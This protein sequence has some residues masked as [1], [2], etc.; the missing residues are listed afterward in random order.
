MIHKIKVNEITLTSKPTKEEAGKISNNINKEYN[1]SIKDLSVIVSQPYAYTWTPFYFEGKRKKENWISQSIF[2]LDFDNGTEINDIKTKL[3][4]LSLRPNI[5]YNTLSDTPQKR[6]FRVVFFLDGIIKCPKTAD[7]IQSKLVEMFPESD[8]NCKTRERMVYPGYSILHIDEL[9]NSGDDFVK[10]I[11]SYV[12]SRDKDGDTFKT[13]NVKDLEIIE[14]KEVFTIEVGFDDDNKIDDVLEYKLVFDK[15]NMKK[16]KLEEIKVPDMIDNFDWVKAFKEIRILKD[17]DDGIRLKHMQIFGLATNLQYIKGG[18]LYMKNKM[19]EVNNNP[20]RVDIDGKKAE[21]YIYQ[22]FA[23]LPYVKSRKY[24]PQS[25]EK[26]SVYDEDKEYFN[27]LE[28]TRWK[29]GRVDILKTE[30]KITLLEAE[31]KLIDEYNRVIN[32]I[33]Y[34]DNELFNLVDYEKQIIIFKV[35][36]GL[37]KTKLLETTKNTLIATKTNQLKRELS[38]RMEEEWYMTPDYPIFSSELIND[39]IRSYT[40][41]NL[42]EDTSRMIQRISEG[43]P[44]KL[45]NKKIFT[46]TQD[47]IDMAE[48]Y[49]KDNRVCRETTENVITTHTRAILDSNF[50]H[51]ILVFD[52][53]PLSDIVQIGRY[54]F[55]FTIFDNTEFTEDVKP[56]EDWLRFQVG[57]NQ[58]VDVPTFTI[59]NYNKFAEFCALN[60]ESNL[61]KLIDS[62]FC[63]KDEQ[64]KGQIMYAIKKQLP[65]KHIIIMSA[66]SPVEIYKYLFGDRVKVI[67]I[68][69]IEKVGKVVQYTEKSWSRTSFNN[70]YKSIGGYKSLLKLKQMVGDMAV[71]TFQKTKKEFPNELPYHFGN[72]SGYDT[73]RGKDL[74]IIGTDN[75]PIYVYFFYAK[76]IGMSPKGSDNKLSNRIVEWGDKRFKGMVFENPILMDIQLSLIVSEGIQASGRNRNLR[77]NCTS[78]VFSNIPLP[79][80]DEFREEY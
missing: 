7:W 1:V 18:L 50:K 59:K 56:I 37:G 74:C 24:L 47:D 43:K 45:E 11:N 63:Y 3:D 57:S 44:I 36:T 80:T 64:L 5:I 2:Y 23:T 20:N 22:Q 62:S 61:I 72:T 58:I 60:G 79:N 10:I 55:N 13:R 51:D 33:N 12:V 49:K 15:K 32:N 19:I 65:N 31:R 14:P 77:E 78:Y 27:I 38:E 41:S 28:T 53:D 69:N 48:Y 8:Q 16:E 71:I 21:K 26:F 40:N 68:S 39:T 9:E 54:S 42:Y 17:F 66:T 52:E 75:K 46:P 6:K 4:L 70:A 25:L 30:Q 76:L 29:R 67:D 35:H 73:L 34:V